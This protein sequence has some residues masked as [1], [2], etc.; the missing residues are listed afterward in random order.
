MTRKVDEAI[1]E[2]L[3]SV[4]DRF[5]KDD[6]ILTYVPAEHRWSVAADLTIAY[7]IARATRRLRPRRR[8]TT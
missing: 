4:F 2:E 1:V 3:K 7:A 8:K 6:T 5:S